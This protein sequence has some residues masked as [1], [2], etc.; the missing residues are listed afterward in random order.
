MQTNMFE[1]SNFKITI[2]LIKKIQFSLLVLGAT[3]FLIVRVYECITTFLAS[4]TG[5]RTLYLPTT[6]MSFPDLTI[7]P[8]DPYNLEKLVQNGIKS[9]DEYRWNSNWNSNQSGKTGKELYEEVVIDIA[10]ILE[11]VFIFL[12]HQ[13]NGSNVLSF[14]LFNKKVCQYQTLF[15]IKEYYYYGDCMILAM[16]DC[17]SQSGV[18]EIALEFN[19]DVHIFLHHKGNAQLEVTDTSSKF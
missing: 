3:G 12:E 15:E 16:P 2:P 19:V 8:A 10:T 9:V 1:P 18:L 13:Y 14:T 7:C 17:L 5:T 6:E 11:K 4:E